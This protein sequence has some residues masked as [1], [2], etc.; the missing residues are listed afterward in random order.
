MISTKQ[1]KQFKAEMRKNPT[2]AERIFADRLRVA[3]IKHRQQVGMGF[4]IADFLID[5]KMLVI[6]LDGSSHDGRSW[7]DQR[8][9]R[10][11]RRVGFRVIRIPNSEAAT[12]PL[13]NIDAYDDRSAACVNSAFGKMG[14]I[15]SRVMCGKLAPK[16]RDSLFEKRLYR[17]GRVRKARYASPAEREKRLAERRLK[18]TTIF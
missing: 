4:Y 10:F 17:N 5:S 3:G 8:R 12:W 18:V 15:K 2:R 11:I 9:D 1:R 6:E 16:L 7:Y 14:A 13:A